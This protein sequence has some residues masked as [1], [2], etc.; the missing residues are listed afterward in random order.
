MSNNKLRLYGCFLCQ[1]QLDS[2]RD[3]PC[4][5]TFCELCIKNLIEKTDH[6]EHLRL[7]CPVCFDTF[8]AH[9]SDLRLKELVEIFPRNQLVEDLIGTAD[10]NEVQKSCDPCLLVNSTTAVTVGRVF[11][12]HV[13]HTCIDESPTKRPIT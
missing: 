8:S 10:P 1:K 9:S 5:H 13:T 12:R 4:L 2:P 3:L 7:E 6:T 11:A